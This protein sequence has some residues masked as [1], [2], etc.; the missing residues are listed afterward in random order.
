M[1]QPEQ[2][3]SLLVCRGPSKPLL[4]LRT[5]ENPTKGRWGT[6]AVR[7][8][9]SQHA[10]SGCRSSQLEAW[11]CREGEGEQQEHGGNISDR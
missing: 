8:E 4:A 1:S 5:P 2:Y 6:L 11:L 7:G 10:G 3:S 9:E